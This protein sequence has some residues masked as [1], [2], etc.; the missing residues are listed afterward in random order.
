MADELDPRAH[1]AADNGAGARRADR[2]PRPAGQRRRSEDGGDCPG[3]F[4]LLGRALIDTDT[5]EGV[6]SL[7]RCLSRGD[8][9]AG[10]VTGQ[11][12]KRTSIQAKWRNTRR[13]EHPCRRSGI[14]PLRASNI[15][16][17]T[18]MRNE[19]TKAGTRRMTLSF[20]LLAGTALGG[21][22]GLH[23]SPAQ[24]D[25]T[26]LASFVPVNQIAAVDLSNT[27]TNDAI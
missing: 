9:I 4:R 16:R 23:A 20:V 12:N 5:A 26:Q 18:A 25:G 27:L 8:A 22:S 10:V 3:Q 13:V 14:P 6:R 1:R 24:A 19:D 7:P 11:G 17:I 2:R 21:L 15:G